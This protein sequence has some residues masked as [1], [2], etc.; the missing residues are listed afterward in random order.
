M[1]EADHY[2]FL[3]KMSL[4]YFSS[5]LNIDPITM[6]YSLKSTAQAHLTSLGMCPADPGIGREREGHPAVRLSPS[7]AF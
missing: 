6:A 5:F 4:F 1:G 3:T 2:L 7:T